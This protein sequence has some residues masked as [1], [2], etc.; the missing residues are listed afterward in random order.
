M[1]VD[2]ND[3]N[4]KRAWAKIMAQSWT[5]DG[6]RRRLLEDPA[7]V[8]REHDVEVPEG[9]QL[10]IRELPLTPFS[11]RTGICEGPEPATEPQ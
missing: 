11:Q 2:T 7:G 8:L 1:P 5:D 10:T 9:E 3:P 6:L 4:F